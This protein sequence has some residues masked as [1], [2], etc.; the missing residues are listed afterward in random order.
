MPQALEDCASGAYN[1]ECIALERLCTTS[2][3]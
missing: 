3:S 1:L 2:G